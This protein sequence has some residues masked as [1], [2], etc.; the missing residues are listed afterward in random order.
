MEGVSIAQNGGE[1]RY[2]VFSGLCI[3]AS[4]DSFLPDES[5]G[6]QGV[7]MGLGNRK[8][9]RSAVSGILDLSMEGHIRGKDGAEVLGRSAE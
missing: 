2:C 4:L 1:L 7:L 8:G 6:K 5:Q 3:V 9:D